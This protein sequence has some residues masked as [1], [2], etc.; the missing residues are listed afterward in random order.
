MS[1][2]VSEILG[3]LVQEISVFSVISRHGHCS[4]YLAESSQC[5]GS[6]MLD[7]EPIESAVLIQNTRVSRRALPA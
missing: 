1:A 5:G 3:L 2:H 7:L 4:A 6:Q